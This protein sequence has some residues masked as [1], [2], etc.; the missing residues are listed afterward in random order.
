MV[1]KAAEEEKYCYSYLSKKQIRDF[2]NKND[3]AENHL[4]S[5]I[6]VYYTG[7]MLHFQFTSFV[8]DQ[9]IIQAVSNCYTKNKKYFN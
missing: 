6:S 5:I 1:L 3:A 8:K 9:F 4:V 2:K 7:V